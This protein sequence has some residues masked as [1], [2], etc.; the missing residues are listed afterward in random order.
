MK[1]F[2][3][4]TWLF[5]FL[6]P[7]FSFSQDMESEEIIST[8]LEQYQEN[9][10]NIKNRKIVKEDGVIYERWV[11]ENDKKIYNMRS[12]MKAEGQKQTTIYDGQYYYY[13]DPST[14]EI[15]KKKINVNPRDFYMQLQEIGL[16]LRDKSDVNDHTCYVLKTEDVPLEE[17]SLSK[18]PVNS[19]DAKNFAKKNEDITYDLT[20]Y[21]DIE[22][23]IIRKMDI[24]INEMPIKQKG[25]RDIQMEIINKDFREVSGML[26]AFKTVSTT[27]L[28]MT[29]EEKRKA[30]KTRKQM[31]KMKEKMENMPPEQKEMIKSRM[32]KAN[33]IM[34]K[35]EI[36]NVEKIKNIEVNTGL[37][38]DLFDPDSIK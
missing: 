5:L 2:Y 13:K 4:I 25:E 37:D 34:M 21:I 3:S 24:T 10:E 27:K 35:G 22:E 26:M 19:A 9:M 17:L 12:E 7:M 33:S 29:E 8:M 36:E 15:S 1:K 31:K 14:N 23:F 11:K 32:E 30:E 28:D 16:D 18:L 38:S 20:L 6:M